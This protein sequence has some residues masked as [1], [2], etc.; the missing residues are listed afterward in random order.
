MAWMSAT[1]G[2]CSPP[3]AAAANGAP[4]STFSMPP[5]GDTSGRLLLVA[6]ANMC[7]RAAMR[8]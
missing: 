5:Q 1:M 7:A 2:G 3:G 8:T 6:R 4:D